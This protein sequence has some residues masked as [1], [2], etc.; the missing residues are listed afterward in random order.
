MTAAILATERGP[1]LTDEA[2]VVAAII[3]AS[4]IAVVIGR[5][6]AAERRRGDRA[7]CS[8]RAADHASGY[9]T[10]PETAV[11]VVDAFLG[12]RLPDGIRTSMGI[13]RQRRRCDCSG[14]NCRCC[15]ELQVHQLSPL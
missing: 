15:Q 12:L 9:F 1:G 8:D 11:P 7:G 3:A 5:G 10:R 2:I 14:K 4:V 13:L 6:V